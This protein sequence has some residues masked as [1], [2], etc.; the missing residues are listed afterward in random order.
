MKN[1]WRGPKTVLG[2]GSYK[3]MFQVVR[4]ERGAGRKGNERASD[5]G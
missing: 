2:H 4:F 1:I 5:E 3:Y